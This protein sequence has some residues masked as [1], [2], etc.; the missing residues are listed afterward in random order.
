MYVIQNCGGYETHGE[1]VAKGKTREQ[2]FT[3]FKK[4]CDWFFNPEEEC[5]VTKDDEYIYINGKAQYK[6][7]KI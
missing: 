2:A 6:F 4:E 5:T 1:I 3:K 7:E